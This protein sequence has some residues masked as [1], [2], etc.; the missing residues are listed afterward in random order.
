MIELLKGGPHMENKKDEKL[1]Y[2]WELFSPPL[3]LSFSIGA[4]LNKGRLL[5]SNGFLV[6][7]K[8]LDL[9]YNG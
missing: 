1:D 6:T 4:G 3:S 7:H 8:Y 9:I 2:F 5:K